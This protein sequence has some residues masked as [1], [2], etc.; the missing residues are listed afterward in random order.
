[1][2]LLLENVLKLPS[3]TLEPPG[4]PKSRYKGGAPLGEATAVKLQL[5]LEVPGAQAKEPLLVIRK[6][7]SLSTK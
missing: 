3:S 2:Q 6:R 7:L 4:S 1:M 5:P